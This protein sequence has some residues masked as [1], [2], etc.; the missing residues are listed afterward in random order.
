MNVIEQQRRLILNNNR[1][2]KCL[3]FAY[4]RMGVYFVVYVNTREGYYRSKIISRERFLK[5]KTSYEKKYIIDKEETT[6]NDMERIEGKIFTSASKAANIKLNKDMYEKANNPHTCSM[7]GD[8][9]YSS[10]GYKLKFTFA[11]GVDTPYI[12]LCKD[13]YEELEDEKD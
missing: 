6:S 2:S 4:T 1:K 8:N 11:S 7:C 5:A 9:D 12:F 13:C 3:L 10:L